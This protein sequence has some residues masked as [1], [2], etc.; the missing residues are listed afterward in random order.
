[1]NAGIYILLFVLLTFGVS[2]A[3]SIGDVQ[4]EAVKIEARTAK[5]FAY[6][7]YI[8]VPKAMR[9]QSEARKRMHTILVI[10]N[11]A[12]KS[13]DDF[14]VHEA[15]AVGRLLRF[16]FTRRKL[17]VIQPARAISKRFPAVSWI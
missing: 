4:S 10:P 1:M 2:P 3:Q 12:G 7:Y 8:Y 6:P 13:S 17:C 16:S 15:P 5:G 9:G 11:N 14:T